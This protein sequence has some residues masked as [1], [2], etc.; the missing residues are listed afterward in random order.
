MMDRRLIVMALAPLLG[1]GGAAAQ[2][3]EAPAQPAPAAEP[4]PAAPAPA[5]EADPFH[6]TGSVGVGGMHTDTTNTPDASKLNEYRDLSS[7]FLSNFDVKGRNSKYWM[8]LFGENLGRDDEYVNLRGGLYDV[9]KYRLY[10]DSLR[11]NFL[12]NGITP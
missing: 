9:F 12:F 7:G 6:V 1:A 11:H 3:A 10:T 2:Q 8:D 4:T 5:A